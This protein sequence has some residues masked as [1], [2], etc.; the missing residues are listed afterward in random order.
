MNRLPARKRPPSSVR[1]LQ[2]E[3]PASVAAALDK[4]SSGT[5]GPPVTCSGSAQAQRTSMA[6]AAPAGARTSS[7]P[8]GLT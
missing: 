1:Q 6:T 3:L 4:L 5:D 2:T 8:P 7:Q